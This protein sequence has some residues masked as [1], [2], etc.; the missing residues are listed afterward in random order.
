[1]SD[2][3]LVIRNGTVATAADTTAC[4]IGITDGLVAMLGKNLGPGAHEIDARDQGSCRA[5]RRGQP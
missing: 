5:L 1:M 2:F 4:D 3:D